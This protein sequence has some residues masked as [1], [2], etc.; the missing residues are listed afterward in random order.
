MELLGLGAETVEKAVV[1]G[2]DRVELNELDDVLLDT[3]VVRDVEDVI[4]VGVD[5]F[6]MGKQKWK[7]SD[8]S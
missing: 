6:F 2:V 3:L 1:V 8:I 7:I 5:T 4:V